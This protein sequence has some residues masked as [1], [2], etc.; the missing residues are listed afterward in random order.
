MKGRGR[1]RRKEK[2]KEAE[3][4]R[5]VD[6]NKETGIDSLIMDLIMCKKRSFSSKIKL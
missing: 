1:S 5:E 3:R 2:R 6:K 4:C